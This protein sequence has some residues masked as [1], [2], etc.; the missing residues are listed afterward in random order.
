MGNHL[1]TMCKEDH[2]IFRDLLNPVTIRYRKILTRENLLHVA[3]KYNKKSAEVILFGE[4]L[5]SNK[6][7]LVQTD[8]ND[9]TCLFVAC[10][11]NES[12]VEIIMEKAQQYGLLNNLLYQC[13]VNNETILHIACRKSYRDVTKPIL[14]YV[15]DGDIL[16]RRDNLGNTCVHY[17]CQYNHLALRYILDKYVDIDIDFHLIFSV[18][19]MAGDSCLTIAAR[20]NINSLHILL[21]SGYLTPE[22]FLHVDYYGE[23]F[24]Q[25]LCLNCPNDAM[26]VIKKIGK[27][28][29]RLVKPCLKIAELHRPGL[30]KI[31][32]DYINDNR[33]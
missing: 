5:P 22:I 18:I 33:F 23:T 2:I 11:H 31:I 13:N 21:D 10:N 15:I 32:E 3:C 14:D 6:R 29:N 27:G 25:I 24:L 7:I 28:Y 4:L 30:K 16:F 9:E 1:F 17:A 26:A 19:N 20:S 12:L 8:K